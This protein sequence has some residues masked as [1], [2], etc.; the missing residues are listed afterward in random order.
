M[1][2]S[3]LN[4]V[5]GGATGAVSAIILNPCQQMI[6]NLG[7][8]VNRGMAKEVAGMVRDSGSFRVLFNGLAPTIAR[9]VV[10]GGV[11]PGCAYRFEFWGDLPPNEQWKANGSGWIS[12][13]VVSGPFRLRNIHGITPRQ[14]QPTARCKS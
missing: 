13:F 3:S 1:Q 2:H 10:F 14:T 6:Q 9:D 12:N 7:S 4:F 8:R 11:T 5:A